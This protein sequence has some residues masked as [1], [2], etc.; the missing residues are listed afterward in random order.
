[1]LS[2]HINLF[3]KNI[4]GLE[5][6]SLSHFP[7]NFWRTIFLL[8]YS[9]NWSNFAVWLTLLCE[10]LGNLCITIASQLV[11][12]WILKLTLSFLS[13]RFPYM[14]KTWQKFKYLENEKSFEDEIK[15]IFHHFWRAFNQANNKLFWNVRVRIQ[16]E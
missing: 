1:M 15:S 3:L 6:V 4:R 8:L 11:T 9:I 5:L 10:I 2:P 14:T 12:S 13:S 7:H 16:M